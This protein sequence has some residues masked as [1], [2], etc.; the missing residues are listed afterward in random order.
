MRAIEY[1]VLLLVT[2]PAVYLAANDP[3]GSL[4][5][6]LSELLI[7]PSKGAALISCWPDIAIVSLAY[8]AV[9]L[10]TVA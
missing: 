5:N 3:A 1:Q 10:P 2:L 8:N 7:S 6:I 4:N 9:T